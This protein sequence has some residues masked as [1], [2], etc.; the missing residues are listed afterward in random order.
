MMTL[1]RGKKFIMVKWEWNKSLL[2]LIPIL[3][4]VCRTLEICE[5]RSCFVLISNGTEDYIALQYMYKC[6]GIH[7]RA[8]ER[9]RKTKVKGNGDDK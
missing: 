5:P 4:M 3:R 6:W 8:R 1:S 2:L 7:S 9:K